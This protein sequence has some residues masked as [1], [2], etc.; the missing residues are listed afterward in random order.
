LQGEFEASSK[1]IFD[2]QRFYL[3]IG[4]RK[5]MKIGFPSCSWHEASVNFTVSLWFFSIK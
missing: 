3:K 4:F 2:A 1:K 5:E